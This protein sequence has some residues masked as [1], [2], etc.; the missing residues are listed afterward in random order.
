MS[1]PAQREAD[2]FR[3]KCDGM[4][5]TR[6]G[7]FGGFGGFNSCGPFMRRMGSMCCGGF[8]PSMGG[9]GFGFSGFGGFGGFGGGFGRW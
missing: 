4:E 7:G 9:F 8:M 2:Y 3:G 1:S 5:S 6:M